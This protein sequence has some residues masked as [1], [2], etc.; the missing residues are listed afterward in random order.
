MEEPRDAALFNGQD[1][2]LVKVEAAFSALRE[3]P[4]MITPCHG[5]IAMSKLSSRSG[6]QVPAVSSS[7]ASQR[8]DAL[9]ATVRSGEGCVE[10]R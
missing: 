6:R 2:G 5:L 3:E 9:W 4:V 1:D 8:R 7:M 10:A